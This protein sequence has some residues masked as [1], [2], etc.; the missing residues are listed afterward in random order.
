VGG[1]ACDGVVVASDGLSLACT[2]PPMNS[3][4]PVSVLVTDSGVTSNGS[5]YLVGP[6]SCAT[7]NSHMH[8][9]MLC[10]R[11][12]CTPVSC[13]SPARILVPSTSNCPSGVDT[14]LTNTSGVITLTRSQYVSNMEWSA[15]I[16][17]LVWCHMAGQ[18]S[19]R[20]FPCP[21]AGRCYSFS[22]FWRV[23]PPRDVGQPVTFMFQSFWTEHFWDYVYVYDGPDTSSPV[24]FSG[25]LQKS[26]IVPW[27]S[28]S[29]H[30]RC[31]TL[32][33]SSAASSAA[34]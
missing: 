13:L 3:T 15:P 17:A 20:H 25:C 24:I 1:Q 6:W 12:L 8:T 2:K 34:S 22:S 10:T 19:H 21:Y 26:T 32:L 5:V 18:A 14:L 9:F 30:Q 33:C 4:G 16:L 27:A 29:C 23:R 28:R 7:Y 31:K 11:R